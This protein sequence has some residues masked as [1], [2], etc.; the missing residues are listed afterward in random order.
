MCIFCGGVC[1]G[2]GDMLLPSL[3]AASSL[4]VMRVRLKHS[5]AKSQPGDVSLVGGAVEPAPHDAMGADSD[6]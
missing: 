6:E 1:G 5:S 2:A 3:V 4:V